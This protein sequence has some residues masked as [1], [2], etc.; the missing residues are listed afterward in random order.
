[1]N[2]KIFEVYYQKNGHYGGRIGSRSRQDFNRHQNW[3]WSWYQQINRRIDLAVF[4]NKP[5]VDLGGGIG[6]FA[7]LLINH[8]FK[9]VT[10]SDISQE[11]LR[12]S[13][14]F[15]PKLRT[16]PLDIEK[17][18]L[19]DKYRLAFA[20]EVI[21]HLKNPPVGLSKIHQLLDKG[22]VFVGTSPYP[23]P[24]AFQD[25]THQQVLKPEQWH[26]LFNQA[27]FKTIKTYPLSFPP[28][29]YRISKR[30][31]ICL[32]WYIKNKYFVSTTLIIAY[33]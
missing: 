28:C 6:A 7:G 16:L 19:K 21:E 12:L 24:K 9:Q 11:A 33:K 22:G 8:G 20:L 13:Q 3:Y 29:L 30:F 31:N 25:P 15:N 32:P 2:H 17:S 14:K 26:N 1:M 4:K 10:N 27:G 5:A 23:F 18:N